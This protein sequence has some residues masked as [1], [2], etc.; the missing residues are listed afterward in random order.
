MDYLVDT[1]ILLRFADRSHPI[2]PQ[3]RRAI[4][5]FLRIGNKLFITP[6]NAIEFWNVATRPAD[7]NGFGLTPVIANRLLRRIER[8]FIL[9][10]DSPSIYEK[11]R[12]LVVELNIS[13]VQVHDARL[14]SAMLTYKV[15]HILT[16][17]INDFTRYKAH[18]LIAVSPLSVADL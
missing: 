2:N 12:W 1:N 11:W 9:L 18:G 8:L 13:G 14:A 3:I 16:F 7:K 6:Q 10:P 5:H 17:N 4:R 15:T